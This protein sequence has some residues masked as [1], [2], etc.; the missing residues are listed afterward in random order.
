MCLGAIVELA[1]TWEEDGV[2]VGRLADGAVVTL[3][4]VPEAKVGAQLLVHLGIPV[5]V[6]DHATAAEA[7]SLRQRAV[8]SDHYG[9]TT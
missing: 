1:D 2:R 7:L 4:F 5:E 6:L 8:L 3:A 9:G